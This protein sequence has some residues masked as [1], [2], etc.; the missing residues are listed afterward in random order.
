M[1][2]LGFE[3]T[4]FSLE[5]AW[6]DLEQQVAFLDQRT[7]G[8]GHFVDLPGNPWADL[9][10]FRRFKAPGEL[11]PF[12]DRLLQYLGHTDFGRRHGRCRV[13]SLAA[14][15]HHQHRQQREGKTQ[16]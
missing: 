3:T 14:S 7:F 15:A 10:G 9:D 1:G 13:G 8:E 12:V 2:Q 16:F 5:G 11:I 4:Y 6:V